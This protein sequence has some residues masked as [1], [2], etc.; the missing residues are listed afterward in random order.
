M[1][2]TKKHHR[3]RILKRHL[4]RLEAV[5]TILE[6]KDRRF[7]WLR[8]STII[9][10][11]LGLLS[12]FFIE[13]IQISIG[14]MVASVAAFTVV[15]MFHR[16]V[17]ASLSMFT[18]KGQQI[19]CQLARMG[20]N[21]NNIP[22]PPV[23]DG[24]SRLDQ[25]LLKKHPFANDIGIIGKE[26]LTHLVDVT[27]TL[28]G[29]QRLLSWLIST[30]PD[31]EVITRR[32]K[33]LMELDPL[34][35]F[36]SRL[37]LSSS[38]VS[39]KQSNRRWDGER[40]IEWLN[41]QEK[42]NSL[43][44]YFI[45][46]CVFSVI[47]ISLFIANMLGLLSPIWVITLGIYAIIYNIKHKQYR[48]LFGDAYQL[49][50]LLDQFK[51][52]F[53]HLEKY[54]Y[55][56]QS[57][58]KQVCKPFWDG[59]AHPSNYLRRISRVISAASLK[60]NQILWVIVNAIFPWDMYFTIRMQGYKTE[61]ADLFPVWMDR[62]YELEALNSLS[63][64]KYLNPHFVYP[65]I[66]QGTDQTS[67]AFSVVNLGHPLIPDEDR[68]CNDFE[69]A[70]LGEV[71]LISGSN[72][73]GKSTFL[74]T[75]GINL[76]MAFAGS[77]VCASALSTRQF[78]LFSVITVLDSLSDGISYFYAEVKR[79]KDLLHYLDH[80]DRPPVFFLIDEIF[81]GTNNRERQIGSTSYVKALIGERGVGLISTHDLALVKLAEN[82]SHVRNFHFREDVTDGRMVF[83]YRLKSGPCPTTN[84]LRIMALEGLPVDEI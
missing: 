4:S 45:I 75:V 33:I 26:S 68:V 54:P 7:F 36:R 16:R 19:K 61:L 29:S 42:D 80:Q 67:P 27:I 46:L 12:L 1:D 10:F 35:G 51:A 64:L 37:T 21:W 57:L 13:L 39:G 55:P 17:D 76:C 44:Y 83:D 58:L 47:N 62:W 52:L 24:D 15:V 81:R 5:K 56:D 71:D 50:D 32:Q 53:S 69:L 82:L 63:N 41:K 31:P 6:Q 78:R 8:L 3:Y 77:T 60:N 73:S 38:N 65:E 59:E 48:D 14:I 23:M 43:V 22:V 70:S 79:L 84:A 9:F 28:G 66:S 18:N 40:I 2:I 74:R 25:E 34:Y 30:N 20:L 11:F 72:M 49:G